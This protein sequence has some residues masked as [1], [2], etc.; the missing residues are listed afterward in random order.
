[1]GL[2]A[3]FL[4]ACGVKLAP[5]PALFPVTNVWK[6]DVGG[7]IEPPLAT[8]GT[9]LFVATRDGFVVAL[10]LDAGKE[11]WRVRGRGH[12]SAT[13]AVLVLREDSGRLRRL[14]PASGADLWRAMTGVEGALPAAIDGDAVFVAGKG[15]GAFTTERGEKLWSAPET[16]SAVPVASGMW[17]FTSEEDGT[18]RGRE[19][20]SGA[21]R[22]SFPTGSPVRAP[23]VV[24]GEH[25]LLG[26]T[27]GRLLGLRLDKG[28]ARWRWKIGAD[29]PDAGLV[30]ED[31]ALFVSYDN[32]LYA[33][34]RG[35]GHLHWRGILPSRP[36]SGPVLTG[37]AVLVACQETD[38]LGFDARSGAR[39]GALQTAAEIRTPPLVVG[40]Q[41]YVGLRD[42]SVVALALNQAAYAAPSPT[43]APTPAARPQPPKP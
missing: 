25:L 15:L 34:G 10:S 26:T 20:A 29:V 28:T 17:L 3:A 42:R 6:A 7:S 35:N 8:D 24:D 13:D 18:L 43:P 41:L 40:T 33:V 21:S 14:D 23:V 12:V 4:V 16:V 22:W 27:D 36:V 9:R 1:M 30:F 32:I 11:L 37:S 31:N 2:M 19:R 5:P 39:L 38:I